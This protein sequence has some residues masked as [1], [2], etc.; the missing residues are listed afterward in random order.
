MKTM[1]RYSYNISLSLSLS[2]WDLNIYAL[3]VP[4]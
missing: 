2:L 4:H 3:D 1:N